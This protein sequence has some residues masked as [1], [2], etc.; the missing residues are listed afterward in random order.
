MVMPGCE[1]LQ[2]LSASCNTI[3]ADQ[4]NGQ[5]NEQSKKDKSQTNKSLKIN[6]LNDI[7]TN[8]VMNYFLEEKHT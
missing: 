4:M 5:D 3:D 6:L 2:L 7:K 8:Q 1:R